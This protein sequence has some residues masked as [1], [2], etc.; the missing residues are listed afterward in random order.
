MKNVT[1]ISLNL[2][3]Y[4]TNTLVITNHAYVISGIPSNTN[5]KRVNITKHIT[6]HFSGPHL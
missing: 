3:A 4:V 1:G 6:K 5:H 2:Y